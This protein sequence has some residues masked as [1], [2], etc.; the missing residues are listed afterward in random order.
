[1]AEEQ[2]DNDEET[3]ACSACGAPMPIERKE[4]LGV[5]TCIKCTRQKK[6]PKGVWDYPEGFHERNEGVGGLI[7]LDE[8]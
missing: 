2:N 8:D 3:I 6:P 7:I 1:M 4:L 5:T